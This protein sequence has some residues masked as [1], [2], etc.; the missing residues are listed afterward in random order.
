M[1]KLREMIAGHLRMGV[2]SLAVV[3]VTMVDFVS[4][5]VSRVVDGFFM[6]VAIIALY[7]L[8]KKAMK[9]E[10]KEGSNK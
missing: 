6:V 5:I 4:G 8:L 1:E 7:P 9:E 10:K 2:A 3:L